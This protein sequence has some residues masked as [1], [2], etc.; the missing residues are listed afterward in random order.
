MFKSWCSKLFAASSSAMFSILQNLNQ[1]VGAFFFFFF[2]PVKCQKCACFVQLWTETRDKN[3]SMM[4]SWG[5]KKRASSLLPK[6]ENVMFE[7]KKGRDLGTQLDGPSV[8]L[9]PGFSIRRLFLDAIVY[10]PNNAC[11]RSRD[12]VGC[13][14]LSSA[15]CRHLLRY[16]KKSGQ[17]RLSNLNLIST[18]SRH[19][20]AR[21]CLPQC[22]VSRRS[23]NAHG[24]RTK[25]HTE[26]S[27]R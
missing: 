27:T 3:K 10:S 17:T 1:S 25:S 18:L 9:R 15:R 23:R 12:L 4:S 24:S 11:F 13:I 26:R 14:P 8:M 22:W 5:G 6:D 19:L 20:S 16:C 2:P 7:F 21:V